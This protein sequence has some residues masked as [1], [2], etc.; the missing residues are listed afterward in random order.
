MLHNSPE[1]ARG[2]FRSMGFIF[3]GRKTQDEG[4]LISLYDDAMRFEYMVNVGLKAD[5]SYATITKTPLVDGS[6]DDT[7]G[8]IVYK[9]DV[10]DDGFNSDDYSYLHIKDEKHGDVILEMSEACADSPFTLSVETE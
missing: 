7:R 10:I 3:P 8:K 1:I 4:I 5:G 9:G 6:P 2:K